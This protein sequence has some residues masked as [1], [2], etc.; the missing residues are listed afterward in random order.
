MPYLN[1][2]QDKRCP[3][4]LTAAGSNSSR[5]LSS[6]LSYRTP[7]RISGD[8]SGLDFDLPA[9]NGVRRGPGPCTAYS[10]QIPMFRGKSLMT[11]LAENKAIAG[12]WFDAFWGKRSDPD[13]IEELAGPNLVFQ[14]AADQTC[15]GSQEALA[16]MT[17]LREAVPDFH[18][19][20]S[21]ITAEREIVIVNWE[22]G[23]THT[24]P[25]FE[26]LQVGPLPAESGHLVT[27]AGHSVIEVKE[28]RIAGEWVWSIKR[29]HQMRDT[30]L[31]RLAL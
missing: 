26:G 7:R 28:G 16:F 9:K 25:A 21:E 18:L 27:V 3:R 11:T 8:G 24:G 13:V 23:G 1:S 5:T 22:G 30:L 29:H 19:S 31:K 14:S 10:S 17:K 12:R 4:C 6:L 15:R 20:V 2:T